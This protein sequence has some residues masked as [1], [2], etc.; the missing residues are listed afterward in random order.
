M[1][2]KSRPARL[3]KEK[4]FKVFTIEIEAHKLEVRYT[5]KSREKIITL[6][7]HLIFESKA[8]SVI[9]EFKLGDNNHRIKIRPDDS[10][11]FKNPKDIYIHLDDEPIQHSLSETWYVVK[12]ARI[13]L[14]FL[15]VVLAAKLAIGPLIEN[16]GPSVRWMNELTEIY[17]MQALLYG[18][19]LFLTLYG[20]LIFTRKPKL[21]IWIGLIVGLAEALDYFASIGN[22]IGLLAHP[23][24][25]ITWIVVRATLYMYLITALQKLNPPKYKYNV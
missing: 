20:I 16:H 17:K 1:E 11:F 8:L 9:H 5:Y 6:D 25:I 22:S 10:V 19:P 12:K 14:I 13:S 18:I 21:A 15:S 23:G 4:E 7:G 2:F 24:V 3:Y